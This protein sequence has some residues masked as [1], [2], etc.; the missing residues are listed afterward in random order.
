MATVLEQLDEAIAGHDLVE[1]ERAGFDVRDRGT[2]GYPLAKSDNLLMLSLFSDRLDLDG[3][4]VLRLRDITSCKVEFARKA[5][6]LKALE[7]KGES[8]KTPAG[9]DL[10]SLRTLLSTVH[11]EFPL[12]VI[13]RERLAPGECE[14]G[15][16]KMTSEEAFAIHCIDPSAQ[17]ADDREHY[18]YSDVTRVSFGGEYETTLA[19][20]AGLGAHQ[21]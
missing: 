6:Y 16:L 18:R 13:H 4:E 9:L 21:L 19:L 20:V 14:V 7:M 5:F 17:W 11:H 12:V 3:Y 2:Q 10:T 8:P 15:R 1:I